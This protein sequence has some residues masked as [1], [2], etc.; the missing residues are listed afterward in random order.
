MKKQLRF[1]LIIVSCSYLCIID[2]TDILGQV[3]HPFPTSNAVWSELYWPPYSEIPIPLVHALFEDD[4]LINDNTYSK[5]YLLSDTEDVL[6]NR[7]YKGAIRCDSEQMVFYVPKTWEDEILIYDFDVEIADTIWA[8][9]VAGRGWFHPYNYLIVADIDSIAMQNHYRNRIEA[10]PEPGY[11]SLTPWIEGIGSIRGL[12]FQSGG[13]PNDGRWG[14]LVCFFDNGNLVY[15]N[16]EFENC[17]PLPLDDVPYPK[18]FGD[19]FLKLY[20]NPSVNEM[21]IEC[22]TG[23]IERITVLDINGREV[24]LRKG[25]YSNRTMLYTKQF[26]EGLYYLRVIMTDKK[27]HNKTFIVMK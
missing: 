7:E 10:I 2:N 6:N 23:E 18:D 13:V 3:S 5:L 27:H 20:P 24:Y 11:P 17:Y 16:P 25:I 4:T 19:T 21:I 8:E 14:E 15:H 26:E 12:L 9:P 22:P 1:Y